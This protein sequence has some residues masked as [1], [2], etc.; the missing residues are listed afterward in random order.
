[1]CNIKNDCIIFINF[2]QNFFEYFPDC[3]W[4]FSGWNILI[5]ENNTRK[6]VCYI[7]F[8]R[9]PVSLPSQF[10]DKYN[11]FVERSKNLY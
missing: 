9:G 7:L 4:L 6:F 1:M 3:L 2:L 10:G 5:F 11:H 8:Q